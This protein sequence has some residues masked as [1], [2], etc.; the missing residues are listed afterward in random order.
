MPISFFQKGADKLTK[1][2]QE[3]SRKQHTR[4]K[5]DNTENSKGFE[6]AKLKLA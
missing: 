4:F 3:M 1:L 6:K 5:K 2:Y